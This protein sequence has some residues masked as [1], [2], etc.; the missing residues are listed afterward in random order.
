MAEL[1]GGGDGMSTEGE[2]ETVGFE[3]LEVWPESLELLRV[4]DVSARCDF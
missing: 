3:V 1:Y 4:G 2:R